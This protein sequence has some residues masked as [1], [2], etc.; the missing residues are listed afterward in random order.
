MSF[1]DGSQKFISETINWTVYKQAMTPWG[2]KS[3]YVGANLGAGGVMNP[4][5]LR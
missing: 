2:D 3:G 4:A 5:L 1:C